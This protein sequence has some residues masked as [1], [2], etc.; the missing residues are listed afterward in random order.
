MCER[1][2]FSAPFLFTHWQ[3]LLVLSATKANFK[4][5]QGILDDSHLGTTPKSFYFDLKGRTL[6]ASFPVVSMRF[7]HEFWRSKNVK[8]LVF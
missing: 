4:G 1:S 7:V 5:L 6:I 2:S 3:S 8:I